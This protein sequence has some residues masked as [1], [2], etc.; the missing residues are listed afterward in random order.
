MPGEVAPCGSGVTT[1]APSITLISHEAGYGVPRTPRVTR[2]VPDH[3]RLDQ[4]VRAIGGDENLTG[5]LD[6]ERRE[7]DQEVVLV[8]RREL[9]LRDLG[10]LLQ[11]CLTHAV[12]GLLQRE[13][14]DLGELFEQQ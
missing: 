6:A 12:Q 8:R 3:G 9:D 11:H 5:V 1:W 7:V 4:P 14:V 2:V 10:V 13:T